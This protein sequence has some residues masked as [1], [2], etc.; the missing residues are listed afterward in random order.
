MVPGET[1]G[2]HGSLVEE[3][4]VELLVV[5]A[6]GRR[7][8]R[9]V[10]KVDSGCLD[11][12]RGLSAGDLLSE[13]EVLSKADVSGHRARRSS[14]SLSRWMSSRARLVNALSARTRSISA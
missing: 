8:E 7:V 14:S 10:S 5:E 9:R 2:E 13:L 3:V 12:D 4:G 6:R 11:E 1:A